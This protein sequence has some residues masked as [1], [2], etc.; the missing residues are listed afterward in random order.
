MQAVNSP[1]TRFLGAQ[2]Q[3][4]IPI[5]QRAYSW[6]PSTAGKLLADIIAIAED[7]Q[8]PCHFIGSVI[9]LPMA[10]FAAVVNQDHIIDGQQRL[11]TISLLLLALS[12]Y[13]RSYY[14][15]ENYKNASTRF[16]QISD[17]YLFNK[18]ESGDLIYKL[19]LRGDD[20][21]VYKKLIQY[22]KQC[23]DEAGENNGAGEI[24]PDFTSSEKNNP[25]YRNFYYLL[26]D[27]TCRKIDPSLVI[28][29][30]KKLLLVDIPLDKQDNAQ[31]VF[32]TVNSTGQALTEAE[33]VSNYILMTVP[34][35][36]QDELYEQAW[37]PIIEKFSPDEL[38][39]FIRFYLITQLKKKINDSAY[40][41]EFKDF[42]QRDPRLT[43]EIVSD[44]NHY[45]SHYSVW[46][47]STTTSADDLV[48]L[49]ARIKETKQ[50]RIIPVVLQ[51]LEDLR[52]K[53]CSKEEAR[54]VLQVIESYW[55]RRMICD[56]PSH[57]VSQL[58][59]TM[60]KSLGKTPYL[61]S[62]KHVII[63]VTYA[64]RMPNDEE[65]RSKLRE[66]P[67]YGKPFARMLLE[68]MEG[69]KN[70]DYTHSSNHSIEHIMPQTIQ[71]HDDLYARTDLSEE[72]KKKLDWALALGDDW[73]QIHKTYLNT[74][75]N[76]TLTG[77]NPEYQ[78]YIFTE[79]KMMPNG[80]AVSPIRLTHDTL[81]SL[82][83][84]GE[85]EIIERSDKLAEIIC[86]IWKYPS[87]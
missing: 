1:L 7:T 26:S 62:F 23:N 68:R 31:L 36:E 32:E 29:G 25:V 72:T 4:C 30:V 6:E 28:T 10:Q 74:I 51:V 22:I 46:K 41:N 37:R 42:A 18:Y 38:N 11:T 17:L 48:V 61:E 64:Q 63:D 78:N 66:V 5:F 20:F 52:T 76:L 35:E 70:K 3:Y 77:F 50:D 60:L 65:M 8:R 59:I 67:I 45:C 15:K 16:E 39:R 86:N 19:R 55:M 34:P 84:W 58:I 44:M 54:G 13:S 69:Y 49:I 56:L 12:E 9:H 82:K 24:T 85:K 87:I 75:G 57:S 81:S 14:S 2:N 33:K 71:S 83:T 27:L 43:K 80:Y 40:Y 47:D 21:T 79:K 73:Q 53:K